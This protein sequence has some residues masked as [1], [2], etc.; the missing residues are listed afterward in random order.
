[1]RLLSL[2]FPLMLGAFEAL[3]EHL[4]FYELSHE[5]RLQKIYKSQIEPHFTRGTEGTFVGENGVKIKY[6]LFPISSEKGSIVISSGRT[7]AMVKYK[8]LI[9]DLNHN[10][11]SVYIMDHRGQGYSG[12][13]TKDT[14]MGYVDT[15]DNYAHDLHHFI[16]KKVKTRKPK[17]LFLLGHSLG[18]AIA[19][20]TLELYADGF[21]AAVLT[22]PMLQP[23][24]Y[25]PNTSNL[26]CKLISLEK[27]RKTYAPGQTTYD[28]EEHQ[29]KGNLLTHSTIRFDVAKT[30]SE[31]HPLT[32]IGG[33]SIGWV[34]QA[35]LGSEKTIQEAYKIKIPLLILRGSEDKIVNPEAEDIF[36][37]E[38]GTECFG[39]E[40]KGAWHELLVE[41]EPYREET[42]AAILTFLAVSQEK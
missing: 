39:Y 2:L 28:K 21:E 16:V 11:Y 18:G 27:E 36:C 19:A 3:P 22:S 17:H 1:M 14:Q 4:P 30:E 29:F 10:G 35:C 38:I 6:R 31:E 33:P 7:E 41:K 25:T 32:K 13:M 8:E 26:I 20:R 5:N 37:K 42:V 40:I 34:Q 24:L 12:R 15:F 9:Y 23:N